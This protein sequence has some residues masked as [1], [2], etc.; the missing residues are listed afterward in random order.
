VP[1]PLV[2]VAAL[3][4][5]LG[6]A[7]PAAATPPPVGFAGC[8]G[9][10]PAVEP[11]DVLLA[12]GDGTASFSVARWSRWTRSSARALGSAVIDDCEPSC[13]DGHARSLLAAL[14]L[15]RPR[16]CHGARRFTRLRLV[17]ATRPARGQPAPV[18]YG[19]G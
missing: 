3:A 10:A 4:A 7:A 13:V 1:R 18:T 2:I 15:D 16:S 17:F 8:L 12:C 11:H 9:S 14:V 5:L 6:V 19:C